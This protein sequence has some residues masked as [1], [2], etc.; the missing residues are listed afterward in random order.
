[1]LP[2]LSDEVAAR[3]GLLLFG[4]QLLKSLQLLPGRNRLIILPER[5]TEFVRHFGRL[6][7]ELFCLLELPHSLV[8]LFRPFQNH[9]EIVRAMIRN[10]RRR[11]V[12]L[13]VLQAGDG[14]YGEAEKSLDR[15]LKL[16][17][18]NDSAL[19]AL[20]ALKA[21]AID[22]AKHTSGTPIREP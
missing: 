6:R 7:I 4:P 14:R 21:V 9:A 10:T 2:L 17:P 20:S 15:A 5:K 13:G 12:N 3:G 8:T 1:M 22:P 18:R 16:D 19:K 11:S